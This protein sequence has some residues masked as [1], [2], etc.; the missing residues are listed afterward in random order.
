MVMV[1][2]NHHGVVEGD[3][4]A[5]IVKDIISREEESGV[6]EWVWNPAVQI[7]VILRGRIIGHNRRA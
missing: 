7:I 6:P 2:N 1:R 4:P 5:E 3:E